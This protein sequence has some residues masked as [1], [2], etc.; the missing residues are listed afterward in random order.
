LEKKMVMFAAVIFDWD[1]TLADTHRIVVGG[2]Q[3]ALAEVGVKVNVKFLER[4]IGIGARNSFRDALNYVGKPFDDRLL[5]LL[6]ERKTEVQVGLS[7]KVMLFDGAIDILDSLRGRVRMALATMSNRKIIDKLL[8]EKNVGNYFDEV[9]SV[10]DV[11]RPK[12]DPEIFLRCASK[13]GVSPENCVVM[14]DS[15]FGVR[16]ARSA[17]MKCIVVPTGAYAMEEL[18]KEGPDLL[19]DSL[20][21]REKI[22]SYIFG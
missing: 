16:A 17:R 15:V 9:V 19:V 18:E 10:D 12:P 22:L 5:D 1:G 3:R 2:F 8:V 13:L 6:V 7:G 4:R 14:E 11:Q 21:E 20:L